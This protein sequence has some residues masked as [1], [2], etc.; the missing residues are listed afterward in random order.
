MLKGVAISRFSR[1]QRVTAMLTKE[2]RYMATMKVLKDNQ[3]AGVHGDSHSGEKGRALGM[4][5]CQLAFRDAASHCQQRVLLNTH[6]V[7]L[8]RRRLIVYVVHMSNFIAS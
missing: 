5:H 7:C 4:C 2:A 8:R 3:P 1:L 6:S